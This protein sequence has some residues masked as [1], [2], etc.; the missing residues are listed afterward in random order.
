MNTMA[1]QETA[2]GPESR[3]SLFP[4]IDRIVSPA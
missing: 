3:L 1:E 2:P 4:E